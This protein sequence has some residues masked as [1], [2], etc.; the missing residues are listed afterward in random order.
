MQKPVEIPKKEAAS[1]FDL[2]Y[3][4]SLTDW[5]WQEDKPFSENLKA[6]IEK[7]QNH[8]SKNLNIVAEKLQ[9]IINAP[10]I[11]VS[12]F[13]LCELINSSV[14]INPNYFLSFLNIDKQN[15]KA[16]NLYALLIKKIHPLEIAIKA[17]DPETTFSILKKYPE[18][19]LKPMSNKISVEQN[20][21]TNGKVEIAE[22]LERRKSE[23][24]IFLTPDLIIKSKQCQEYFCD[25]FKEFEGHF[26]INIPQASTQNFSRLKKL[27]ANTTTPV[28]PLTDT[29]IQQEK[30]FYTRYAG[31]ALKESQFKLR[32]LLRKA[33][34]MAQL[35]SL[36]DKNIYNDYL[37]SNIY[38]N[39]LPKAVMEWRIKSSE[40]NLDASSVGH[41]FVHGTNAGKSIELSGA[42][43]TVEQVEKKI[44]AN[45]TTPLGLKKNSFF[46]FNGSMDNKPTPPQFRNRTL[47]WVVLNVDDALYGVPKPTDTPLKVHDLWTSPH[48]SGF[49]YGRSERIPSYLGVKLSV[50]HQNVTN[51]ALLGNAKKYYRLSANNQEIQWSQ[52]AKEEISLGDGR[53]QIAMEIILFLRKL[54]ELP[55]G[56]QYYNYFYAN[57]KNLNILDALRSTLFPPNLREAKSVK[58]ISTKSSYLTIIEN[59]KLQQNEIPFSI[60]KELSDCITENN[61]QKFCDLLKGT[62]N[63][64]PDF[65]YENLIIKSIQHLRPKFLAFLLEKGAAIDFANNKPLRE[66]IYQFI[67]RIK[68]KKIILSAEKEVELREIFDLLLH[69]GTRH[70]DSIR[71]VANIDAC[72]EIP[73]EWAATTF[74]CNYNFF[75]K[76]LFLSEKIPYLRDIIIKET[77]QWKIV[78]TYSRVALFLDEEN[79]KNLLQLSEIKSN[80]IANYDSKKFEIYQLVNEHQDESE[81]VSELK[82]LKSDSLTLLVMIR[83]I[84]ECIKLKQNPLILR[85]LLKHL[86]ETAYN[87]I[88]STLFNEI[89]HLSA[90]VSSEEIFKSLLLIDK[91]KINVKCSYLEATPLYYA[92]LYDNQDIIDYAI[93]NHEQVNLKN[94]YFLFSALLEKFLNNN[95]KGQ[96][97]KILEYL[98]IALES[99]NFNRK[100]ILTIINFCI[101]NNIPNYK[102]TIF[103]TIELQDNKHE[104][105]NELLNLKI[106][107]DQLSIF[108][109]QYDVEKF[110]FLCVENHWAKPIDVFY[111]ENLSIKQ[112]I[113]L[114]RNLLD[115]GM[116]QLSEIGGIINTIHQA[117]YLNEELSL[118]AEKLVYLIEKLSGKSRN[119]YQEKYTFLHVISPEPL[120]SNVNKLIKKSINFRSNFVKACFDYRKIDLLQNLFIKNYIDL[121]SEFISP[122]TPK[123]TCSLYSV[124]SL[125][126]LNFEQKNNIMKILFSHGFS[127]DMDFNQLPFYFS[128]EFLKLL[129]QFQTEELSELFKNFPIKNPKIIDFDGNYFIYYLKNVQLADFFY[130]AYFIDL[131]DLNRNNSNHNFLEILF[132]RCIDNT[133]VTRFNTQTISSHFPLICKLQKNNLHLKKLIFYMAD[134][135]LSQP[136]AFEKPTIFAYF[137]KDEKLLH[138]QVKDLMTLV[139]FTE[140]TECILVSNNIQK[141][142]F[143][144]FKFERRNENCDYLLAPSK[145][146]TKK[147]T[148]TSSLNDSWIPLN[149]INENN[150]TKI[151]GYSDNPKSKA[152]PKELIL[153]PFLAFTL[154]PQNNKNFT[155][156][157]QNHLDLMKKLYTGILKNNLE[158]VKEAYLIL[159]K[160]NYPIYQ[161]YFM[162]FLETDVL[163][164]N[165]NDISSKVMLQAYSPLALALE[166]HLNQENEINILEWLLSQKPLNYI[167]TCRGDFLHEH[168]ITVLPW[169]LLKDNSQLDLLKKL[170]IHLQ[171]NASNLRKNFIAQTLSAQIEK[172]DDFGYKKSASSF[173]EI[174]LNVKKRSATS[175]FLD[176]NNSK[177]QKISKPDDTQDKS[178]DN[179]LC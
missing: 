79:F 104:L 143:E 97:E 152:A 57:Y 35:Q 36:D 133:F 52:T 85:V 45:T 108:K 170:L 37:N 88:Y 43:I 70:S 78:P 65:A 114:L 67:P 178:R 148:D 123:K 74:N 111:R 69:R 73:K 165:N 103:T 120:N 135:D 16:S 77:Y 27:V 91:E 41:V 28:G 21:I 60:E 14:G 34:F 81:I 2:A 7:E 155:T 116:V 115:N 130:Q 17:N 20:I 33:V 157:Y 176:S 90:M 56:E 112:K 110:I 175:V 139:D 160:N 44:K 162:K 138:G 169:L 18:S 22:Y 94:D 40:H 124:L 179:D 42:L 107:N 132:L 146:W 142:N 100:I 19:W 15:K 66:A 145:A 149:I 166:M 119:T 31:K 38:R 109:N 46:S 12:Y 137:S 9:K 121:K 127:W 86:K 153:D 98:K 95:Y 96:P 101:I 131:T 154:D 125:K 53:H 55:G 134:G 11:S 84:S 50:V 58:D 24:T 29:Q 159:Q 83:I 128:D 64:S 30:D 71:F 136:I 117:H 99:E 164:I 25:S 32:Y 13:E 59:S 61:Y 129:S 8:L 167:F 62:D 26:G 140:L 144:N 49:F 75:I 168:N 5:Q 93:I 122:L 151:H 126:R 105:I 158:E 150:T 47:H 1:T 174:Y 4:I 118:V 87:S 48:Y 3:S 141:D 80:Y 89:L 171:S 39:R 51:S 76:I 163:K 161:S 82:Q 172:S 68:N 177:K 173:I 106:E 92:W 72:S 10:R 6:A 63:Y 54:R 156:T 23:L 102:K 147:I 113:Y